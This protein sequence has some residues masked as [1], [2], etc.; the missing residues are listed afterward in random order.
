M[1]LMDVVDPCKTCKVPYKLESASAVRF[2]GQVQLRLHLHCLQC[3]RQ[4]MF[5]FTTEGLESVAEEIG[6]A[7]YD[8]EDQYKV[9]LIRNFEEEDCSGWPVN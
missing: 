2:D 9:D 4:D 1:R 8:S 3:N 6:V 5:K 7:V